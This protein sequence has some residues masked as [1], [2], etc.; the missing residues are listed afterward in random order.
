MIG[1]DTNVV[2]R[3]LTQ[4]DAVQSAKAIW[5]K[6]AIGASIVRLR[7][8]MDKGCATLMGAL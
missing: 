1:L 5:A 8:D 2:V 4:D 3:Y 6:P 7:S